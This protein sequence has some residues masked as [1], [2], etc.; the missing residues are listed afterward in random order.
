MERD[1]KICVFMV[2]VNDYRKQSEAFWS[3]HAPSAPEGMRDFART[4]D[5]LFTMICVLS[6]LLAPELAVKLAEPVKGADK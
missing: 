3:K 4:S 2:L 5:T 1:A 6:E